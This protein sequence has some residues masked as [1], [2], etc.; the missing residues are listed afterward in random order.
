MD[1]NWQL[2]AIKRAELNRW[3]DDGVCVCRKGFCW[4]RR[5]VTQWR[6]LQTPRLQALERRKNY[7]SSGMRVYASI[8][9]NNS[10]FSTRH[11]IFRLF[12]GEIQVCLQME[13][14]HFPFIIK[15]C[16]RLL[17]SLTCRTG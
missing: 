1:T 3:S 11:S 8:T 4:E 13:H 6:T 7:V 2:A 16:N 14:T 5:G 10:S 9:M 17:T 15:Y 12:P